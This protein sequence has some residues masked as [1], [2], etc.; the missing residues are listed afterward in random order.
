MFKD[1][2]KFVPIVAGPQPPF[3]ALGRHFQARFREEN[4]QVA[5]TEAQ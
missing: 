1:P 4:R 3:Q 5:L 2:A